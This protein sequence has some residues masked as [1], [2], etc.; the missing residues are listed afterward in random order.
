M[1]HMQPISRLKLAW[2]VGAGVAVGALALAACGS[3]N[4]GNTTTSG[5]GNVT[6]TSVAPQHGGTAYWAEGAGAKPN[7]IFPFAP[8]SYFSVANLTQFQELMYRPLYYFGPPTSSA[9]T[10]DFQLSLAN[11]PVW[12]NGDKTVTIN[13]KGWKFADGQQVDAQ[14]VIFW[15]NMMEAEGANAWAGFAAGPDQYPGNIASYSAASPTSMV[16]TINLNKGY[17]TNW[18][19]YN[20]LSQITPMPEAWD[21]THAGAAPGSGGCGKVG[22][23]ALTGAATKTACTAVWTFM[24]DNGGKGA[25]PTQSGD[26]ATYGTNPLWKMGADGPWYLSGYNSGSGEATFSPNTVYSGPQKPFLSRFVELPFSQDSTEFSALAA[27]GSG[28]PDVGYLPSQDT[29]AKPSGAAATASG[30]NNAELASNYNLVVAPTWSINYFPENFESTAG[31]N[32]HAGAVFKQLY[33]RQAM[34]EA[35]NQPGMIT[36]ILKGYGSPTYGPVPVNP[37]NPFTTGV[38]TKTGGPYPYSLSNAE[39][40]LKANGW[41]VVPGGV[42]TCAKA[43][44]ATGDCGAGIP[45]GTPASFSE[46]YYDGAQATVQITD[47]EV[48]QWSQLGI[49]VA[50]R[51]DTFDGVLGIAVPCLGS[52]IP[53]ACHNWDLANWGGGWLFAPDYLPTGEEIFATGAGSNSGNYNDATNNSLIVETNQSSSSTVFSQWE[54]YLAEQLPVVWQPDP[55]GETEVSKSIYGVQPLNALANL[56]P[57]YWYFK[58]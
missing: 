33:F 20:E 52:P 39:A 14:S 50:A 2:K 12:S 18:Y 13:L 53:A 56:N 10:V 25:H 19:L 15:Q 48:S 40:L 54:T 17:N 32:H 44:T 22:S 28:A 3:S 24:T 45:A 46:V 6:T 43:G 41:H 9:P 49:K 11:A 42:S 31:A 21:I 36:S 55:V 26:I 1:N 57:E 4:S 7:W 51:G 23:G 34:Q 35:V 30:P 37:P 5:P 38:E 8:L 27:G 16:V 58:A 47:N 29:P